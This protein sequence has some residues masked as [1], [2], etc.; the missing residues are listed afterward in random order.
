[1]FSSGFLQ[2]TTLIHSYP[3]SLL[4]LTSLHFVALCPPFP[5]W[6]VIILQ[7]LK[8]TNWAQKVEQQKH[9]SYGVSFTTASW[10]R[11][12]L[13][14][15]EHNVHYYGGH[16]WP[17]HNCDWV[18]AYRERE[19]KRERGAG[20]GAW[21]HIE[22]LSERLVAQLVYFSVYRWNLGTV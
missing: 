9:V 19:R 12:R 11:P 20:C 8:S 18:L 10:I 22:A 1:M 4:L 21:E 15:R 14:I 5:S 17:E 16:H 7:G 2:H 3:E 6:I 13:L